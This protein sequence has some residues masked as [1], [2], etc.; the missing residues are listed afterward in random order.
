[1]IRL[2]LLL[3][4]LCACA[5]APSRAEV[6]P[7]YYF[8][9]E[10]DEK[11]LAERIEDEFDLDAAMESSLDVARRRIGA[12][13]YELESIGERRIALTL[14][15]ED[16]PQSARDVFG[17][18]GDLDFL[19][20]DS[21]DEQKGGAVPAKPGIRMLPHPDGLGMVAV[22]SEGGL[23]GDQLTHARASL[24]PVTGLPVITLTFDAEGRDKLA[25]MTRAD[26]GKFLA[27]MLD[28]KLLSVPKSALTWR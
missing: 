18:A 21:I 14:T 1:M 20:V 26:V 15:H 23:S 11:W 24:D 19:L 25:E 12:A 6:P 4:M 10:V 5:A 27:I 13:D 22:K 17:I 8:V 3:A 16:A 28:A 7:T 2:L 9:F